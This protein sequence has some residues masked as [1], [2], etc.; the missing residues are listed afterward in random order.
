MAIGAIVSLICLKFSFATSSTSIIITVVPQDYNVNVTSWE[1]STEILPGAYVAVE[2]INDNSTVLNGLNLELMVAYGGLVL[3]EDEPYSGN[4]LEIVA[5]LTW[6]NKAII[7]IAG[8][9]HPNSLLPLQ[10]FQLPIAS[11][12]GQ[13]NSQL[14]ENDVLYLTASTSVEKHPLL[15]FCGFQ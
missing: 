1:K 4:L 11:L 9:L 3:S 13:S 6:Q 15:L 7:G 10:A 5:N 2:N 8:L 12:I 14:P